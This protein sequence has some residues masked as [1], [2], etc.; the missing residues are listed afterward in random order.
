MNNANLG[1]DCHN[2]FE[3][4][5]FT[6]VID[7]MEE[8]AYIRKRQYVYDPNIVNYFSPDHLRMQ[9][10]EDFDNKLT[11]LSTQDDFYETKKK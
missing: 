5:Y 11:R 7:K 8:I 6:P 10:N 4:R 1:Y 2:N 9:I 3:N